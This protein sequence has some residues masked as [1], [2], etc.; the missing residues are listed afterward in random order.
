MRD[1]PEFECLFRAEFT[2]IVRTVFLICHDL[3]RAEELTQEAFLQLYRRWETVRFYQRPGAWVR[4]VAVRLAVRSVKE[5]GRRRQ[6]E[7]NITLPGVDESDWDVLDL[8]RELPARQRAVVV[9]HYVEDAPVT[10]IAEVLG[11]SPATV[12]VH[13]FRARQRLSAQLP[14]PHH[15]H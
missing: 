4:K 9:L 10:R 5:E 12:K 2:H 11:C 7:R 14:E 13:L 8:L 15:G 3:E 6:A 1:D